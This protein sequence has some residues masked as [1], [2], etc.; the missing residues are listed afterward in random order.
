MHMEMVFSFQG[1]N[2]DWACFWIS[3]AEE[4]I[5]IDEVSWQ[6]WTSFLKKIFRIHAL[7]C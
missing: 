3:S 5:W 1:M 6:N 4:N 2:T 7:W